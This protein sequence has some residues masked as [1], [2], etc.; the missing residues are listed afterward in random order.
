MSYTIFKRIISLLSILNI[1]LI[2]NC[3]DNISPEKKALSIARKSHSL[4]EYSTVDLFI[5][6]F[7]TKKGDDIK[8]IGWDVGKLKD[9]EYLVSYKYEIFSFKEGTGKKGFF[10]EVDLNNETVIDKTEEYLEEMQPLSNAYKSEKEIFKEIINEDDL[11]KI[12]E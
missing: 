12:V 8:P 9:N 4:S 5:K 7:I 1:L 6:D 10:F 3:S 2:F 11:T